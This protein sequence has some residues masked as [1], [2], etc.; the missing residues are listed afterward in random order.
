MTTYHSPSPNMFYQQEECII[1]KRPESNMDTQNLKKF[2]LGYNAIFQ[3][4]GIMVGLYND[5]MKPL[6]TANIFIIYIYCIQPPH[7]SSG[8]HV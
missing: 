1:C 4:Q 8:Q 6:E 2:V 7:W 5:P 3:R